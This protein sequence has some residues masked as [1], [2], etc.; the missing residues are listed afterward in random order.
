[1]TNL[2]IAAAEME[3]T[4]TQW[5]SQ[6]LTETRIAYGERIVLMLLR[7]QITA[8]LTDDDLELAKHTI[9]R[10]RPAVPLGSLQDRALESVDELCTIILRARQTERLIAPCDT[11]TDPDT[12]PNVGPMAPLS[13]APIVRPPSPV[14]A[15]PDWSL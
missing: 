14:L 12:R 13:P 6:Q 5:V 4:I 7:T 2:V 10:M 8:M 15:V 1:M 11:P 9:A 3:E